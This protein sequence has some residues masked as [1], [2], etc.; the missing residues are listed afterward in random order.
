MPQ[1]C[2]CLHLSW[3]DRQF[4]LLSSFCDFIQQQIKIEFDFNNYRFV[5]NIYLGMPRKLSF[6]GK[7]IKFPAQQAFRQ[8]FLPTC[9]YLWSGGKP[10]GLNLKIHALISLSAKVMDFL[11]ILFLSLYKSKLSPFKLKYTW[12]NLCW[13][14]FFL[15]HKLPLSF[16]HESEFLL[17]NWVC[18]WSLF[19]PLFN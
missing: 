14:K 18:C 7:L 9:S 2:D 4:I 11:W 8:H 16:G 3:D 19:I 1:K 13:Y 17:L 5:Q 10:P 6:E 15:Y 12:S